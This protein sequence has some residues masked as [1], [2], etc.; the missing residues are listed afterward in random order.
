MKP[1]FLL[2]VRRALLDGQPVLPDVAAPAPKVSRPRGIEGMSKAAN[3]PLGKVE[4]H[5]YAAAYVRWLVARGVADHA[6]AYRLGLSREFIYRVR[7]GRSFKTV[8]AL[9][10]PA[11]AY[12]KGRQGC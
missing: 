3:A 8:D 5:R 1:K 4:E 7:T 11:S 12:V 9:E 2:P 10:P 6:I